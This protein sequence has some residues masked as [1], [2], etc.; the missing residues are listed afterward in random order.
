M[1]TNI[2]Y[3]GL[4]ALMLVACTDELTEQT[5]ITEVPE[6]NIPQE[7]TEGELLVKFVPFG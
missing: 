6:V 2:I 4:A 3:I 7:A 5:V 1:R